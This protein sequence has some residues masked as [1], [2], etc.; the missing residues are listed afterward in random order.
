MLYHCTIT[1][2]IKKYLSSKQLSLS[3][4]G[5][6]GPCSKQQVEIFIRG[7]KSN[8]TKSWCF[9][10]WKKPLLCPELEFL[11]LFFKDLCK[12]KHKGIIM[13]RSIYDSLQN[14]KKMAFSRLR[15]IQCRCLAN[16]HGLIRLQD[17][18]HKY[19]F[20]TNLSKGYLIKK[21]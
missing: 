17:V 5:I 1:K 3:P 4:S 12:T 13:K 6:C 10:F 8:K 14:V 9:V 11:H 18:V 15:M 20:K 2:S 19:Q 21:K 7:P 16:S